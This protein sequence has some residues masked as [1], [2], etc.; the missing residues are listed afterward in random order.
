MIVRSRFFC[1]FKNLSAFLRVPKIVY[2][3]A[4]AGNVVDPVAILPHTISPEPALVCIKILKRV[5][6]YGKIIR[7]LKQPPPSIYISVYQ[8]VCINKDHFI[9]REAVKKPQLVQITEAWVFQKYDLIKGCGMHVFPVADDGKGVFSGV[10]P[11]RA[12]E[13][14][15]YP[16]IVILSGGNGNKT[17]FCSRLFQHF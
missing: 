4:E 10:K 16:I 1:D 6:K 8:T 13:I 12:K 5:P 2:A 3:A 7:L 15:C 14:L 9:K 11:V 17:S